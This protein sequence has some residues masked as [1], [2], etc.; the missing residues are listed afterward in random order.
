M[1]FFGA[2][3]GFLVMSPLGFEARVG[4]LIRIVEA[5]V[6]YIPQD[7]P[8]VLHMLTSWW[9]ACCHSCP[10]ILGF[11]YSKSFIDNLSGIRIF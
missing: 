8:L 5:N 2:C 3:F 1:S 4:C 6:M 10:H 9:P 11:L 7:P